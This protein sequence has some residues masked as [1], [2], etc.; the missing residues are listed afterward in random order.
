MDFVNTDS[1]PRTWHTLTAEDGST[2]HL[3]PGE[4]VDLDLGYDFEDP[5]LKPKAPK[6][7]S[8]KEKKAREAEEAERARAAAE[9]DD[10]EKETEL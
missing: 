7:E 9:G 10:N 2:L 6:K 1:M 8:A 3:E 5:Y 4:S